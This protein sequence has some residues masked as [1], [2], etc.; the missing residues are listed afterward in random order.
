MAARINFFLHSI[1]QSS[2]SRLFNHGFPQQHSLESR[3]SRL[4]AHHLQ[5]A[6]P[7]LLTLCSLVPHAS[8]E[9][10][11]AAPP[12]G[13]VSPALHYCSSCP[14]TNSF[15]LMNSRGFML[16][17]T[18]SMVQ[19]L[20]FSSFTPS[21]TYS[22]SFPSVLVSLGGQKSGVAVIFPFSSTVDRK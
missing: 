3:Q 9:A 10:V 2:C 21:R 7:T 12:L 19:R 18:M 8:S 6:V 14:G 20:I 16:I 17:G 13:T 1:Y 4:Q 5:Q 22:N 11:P 15:T